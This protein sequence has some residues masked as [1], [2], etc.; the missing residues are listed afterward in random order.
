[1]V[2][3]YYENY[4][5]YTRLIPG[6]LEG[7]DFIGRIRENPPGRYEENDMFVMIDE[8]ETGDISQ[9]VFEAH[10]RYIDVQLLIY[11]EEEIYWEGIKHL[12]LTIPYDREKDAAFFQGSGQTQLVKAGMFYILLPSDGHKCCGYVNR[13]KAPYRKII[14]K[15]PVK[16]EG[17]E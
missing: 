12:E 14:L 2:L 10:E 16:R 15:L 5:L 17:E 11:G 13:N 8:G 9:K 1:M 4:E 6:L 3:D 7:A